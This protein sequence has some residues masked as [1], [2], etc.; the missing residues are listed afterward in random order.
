VFTKL[1]KKGSEIA[2]GLLNKKYFT[3]GHK[4]KD[5]NDY[6]VYNKKTGVLS[7]DSDGSGSKAAVEF[8]QLKK[9]AILKY[10]DFFII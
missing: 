5:K 7:Y 9:G 3:V 1:G 6:I 2:P 10:S 8:A 4:A